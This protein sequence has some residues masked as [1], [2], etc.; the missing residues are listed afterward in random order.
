MTIS[1]MSVKT[2][3]DSGAPCGRPRVV[4][5]RSVVIDP[6]RI[7]SECESHSCVIQAIVCK[8][9]PWSFRASI[10]APPVH[11]VEGLFEVELCHVEGFAPFFRQLGSFQQREHP[12]AWRAFL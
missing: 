1:A 12:R 8:L 4:S 7:S 11:V 10:A 3:G 2:T 5:K 9:A 6:I